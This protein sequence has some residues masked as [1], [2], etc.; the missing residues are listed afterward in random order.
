[1]RMTIAELTVRSLGSWD[2]DLA[3]ANSSWSQRLFTPHHFYALVGLGLLIGC[4]FGRLLG[5][6]P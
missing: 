4:F 3:S 5:R 2:V 6:S 1:L